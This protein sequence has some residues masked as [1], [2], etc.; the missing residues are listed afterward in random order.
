MTTAVLDASAAAARDL[1]APSDRWSRWP[2]F[3]DD[4][5][6]ATLA[7]LRSGKV[8]YWTGDRGAGVRARVR[9]SVRR[10]PTASRSPTARSRSSSPCRRFGIGAGRRGRRHAAQLRRL[11]EHRRHC[12]APG[13]CSPTSIRTARTSPPATVARGADAA[14]AGD[15]LRSTSPA[16]RATWTESSSSPAHHGLKLIEDCAQ[17]H[18]A[19]YQ[20][21]AGRHASATSGRSRSAR[22]RS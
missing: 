9:E 11:G 13:R 15:H 18:G 3:D 10:R 5:I 17:A 1:P 21:P 6:A 19:P 22:T 8:N 14:H 16:G 7:V 4:Q 12:A 20:R 2:H